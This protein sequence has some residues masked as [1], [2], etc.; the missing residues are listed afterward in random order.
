MTYVIGPTCI[1]TLDRSCVD[2]CPV[3]CIVGDEDDVMLFIDPDACIDCS[4]CVEPCPVEAIYAEEEL[5]KE[6]K[7]W[8]RI[9]SLYFSD[10]DAARDLV[11]NWVSQH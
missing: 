2:V 6:W 10:Q 7:D 11:K 5:P 1:G 3:D 8:T 4:A 9:N